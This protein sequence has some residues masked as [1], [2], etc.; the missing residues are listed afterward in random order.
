MEQNI[1]YAFGQFRLQTDTHLL[2]YE[3]TT[4]RL[5]PK[6]YQLL[7]YFL[8]HT[9]RLISKKELFNEV[10]DGRIVEDS[11]LRLAVNTL[12]KALQDETKTPRYISTT[13][14]CGYRFL[15]DVRVETDS[16]RNTESL[17]TY[18]LPYKPNRN[19]HVDVKPYDFELK[20][21]LDA[22]RET[23]TGKRNLIFLNGH[24]GLGK[25][26]LLERFL[27]SIEKT[28]FGFLRARCVHLESAAEPFLPLLEALERRCQ[29]AYGKLLIEC[30]QQLAPTWLYQ[31]LNVLSSEAIADLESKVSHI[32]TGR[33]LREG[34][35]FFEMLACQ[36]TFILI[37]DNSHWSDEFTLDLVNFLAFR[38]SPANLLIILSYR[39][40]IKFILN[41][42]SF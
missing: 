42:S 41:Y 12:R 5:Q 19:L 6:I 33:M 1:I 24:Q 2:C 34:A 18:G 9:G 28:E 30:L 17:Q 13:C 14:K 8:Q 22:F 32:T 26:A 21:L 36:S 37:L 11:A 29:Q 25:T 20:Q 3:S 27:A 16:Q 23:S 4:I 10:W 39:P 40:D 7:V 35:D 38:C 31:M 15:P